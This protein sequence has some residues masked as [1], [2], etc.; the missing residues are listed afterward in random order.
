MTQQ[1]LL[2]GLGTAPHEQTHAAAIVRGHAFVAAVLR[3]QVC[4]ACCDDAALLFVHRR[5][6]MHRPWDEHV[7]RLVQHGVSN[8]RLAEEIGKCDVVCRRH[9]LPFVRPQM[10]G[11]AWT[12][13]IGLVAKGQTTTRGSENAIA[14]GRAKARGIRNETINVA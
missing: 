11:V 9:L 1:D 3:R 8:R 12:R 4:A 13:S 2:A 14:R 7:A 5:Q 10:L 6:P